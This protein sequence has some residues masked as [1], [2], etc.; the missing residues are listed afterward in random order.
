MT[1]W[2]ALVAHRSAG[3]YVRYATVLA[4][5]R[6]NDNNSATSPHQHFTSPPHVKVKLNSIQR[7][8]KSACAQQESEML[9]LDCAELLCSEDTNNNLSPAQRDKR[10]FC[11]AFCDGRG[12]ERELAESVWD[13]VTM[14]APVEAIALM[15]CVPTLVEDFYKP[16]AA[17]K[18]NSASQT[19]DAKHLLIGAPAT[20]DFSPKLSDFLLAALRKGVRDEYLK[21]FVVV[22][23]VTR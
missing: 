22:Q 15:A 1:I 8:W 23:T 3:D 5:T 17:S 21:S 14:H 6:R 20:I 19:D 16:E 4:T 13:L 10:W 18:S 2:L 9:D 7:V 12:L 11:D